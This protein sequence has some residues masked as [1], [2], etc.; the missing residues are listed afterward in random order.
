[1]RYLVIERFRDARAVYERAARQG[2]M[3][4]P[5][6]AYLD[7]WIVDEEPILRCFQLMET[8]DAALIDRWIAHWDDIV[9]FEVLPVVDGAEAARRAGGGAPAEP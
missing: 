8:D 5:G 3:L 1:V 7:S 9:D 2:R 4:P 6:P